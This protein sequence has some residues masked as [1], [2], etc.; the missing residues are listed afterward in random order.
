M[1][2]ALASLRI[3]LVSQAGFGAPVSGRKNP[4]PGGTRGDTTVQ[5]K[6]VVFPTDG[7]LLDGRRGG[8]RSVHETELTK[9]RLDIA[10]GRT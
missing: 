1:R 7:R 4:V 3:G 8:V 2:V 10:R 5:P 9:S 6:N